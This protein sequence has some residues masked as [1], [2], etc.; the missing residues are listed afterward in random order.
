MNVFNDKVVVVV[1]KNG[2]SETA[3]FVQL[4]CRRIKIF[5][6]RDLE[7]EK[8]ESTE[9]SRFDFLQKMADMFK[10]MGNQDSQYPGRVMRLTEQ[11]VK[12]WMSLLPESSPLLKYYLKRE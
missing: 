3:R 10:L 8:F 1:N 12:S 11:P 4:V 7:R 5:N 6:V 2:H 9:E